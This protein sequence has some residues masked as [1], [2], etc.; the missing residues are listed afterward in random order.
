[1]LG[2]NQPHS[3][4]EV[5]QELMQV[6]QIKDNLINIIQAKNKKEIIT[7]FENINIAIIG[8]D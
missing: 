7:I 3:Q 6:I 4:L 5:L 1:M 8:G 2:L